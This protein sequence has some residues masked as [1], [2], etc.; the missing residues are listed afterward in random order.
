ML[1]GHDRN[2]A[3]RRLEAKLA[4]SPSDSKLMQYPRAIDVDV[5]TGSN[6]NVLAGDRVASQLAA[7][8]TLYNAQR[9]AWGYQNA[10]LGYSDQSKLYGAEAKA[11]KTAGLFKAA[12]SLVGGL[13]RLP[14]LGNVSTGMF[15]AASPVAAGNISLTDDGL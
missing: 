7:E 4:S 5:N 14:G 10:E 15:G 2:M 6:V 1:F 3:G 12:G 11:D 9:A 13:T 8:T